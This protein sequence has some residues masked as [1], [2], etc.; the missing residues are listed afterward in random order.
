MSIAHF[1]S[2]NTNTMYMKQEDKLEQNV[3]ISLGYKI[4]QQFYY[5]ILSVYNYIF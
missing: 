4:M 1:N 5:E 3:D 2:Y